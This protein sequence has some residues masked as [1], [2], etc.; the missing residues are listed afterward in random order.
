MMLMKLGKRIHQVKIHLSDE[1]FLALS[2]LATFEGKELATY[3]GHMVEETVHGRGMRI[4]RGCTD[5]TDNR[6]HEQ[7]L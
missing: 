5:C 4:P 1:T 7:G 2:H 3:I 6:S